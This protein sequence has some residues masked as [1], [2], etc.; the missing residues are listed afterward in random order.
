MMQEEQIFPF[1]AHLPT[2]QEQTCLDNHE[3]EM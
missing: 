2:E 1:C 3:T